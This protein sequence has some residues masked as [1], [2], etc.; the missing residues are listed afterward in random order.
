MSFFSFLLLTEINDL[1]Q[2]TL[3]ASLRSLPFYS[4]SISLHYE[5]SHMHAR[6]LSN[7]LMC[8]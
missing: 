1:Q 4:I 6:A 8:L 3:E 5:L 2:M 7:L